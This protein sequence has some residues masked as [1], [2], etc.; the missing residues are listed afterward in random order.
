MSGRVGC[1]GRV[2]P[3]GDADPAFLSVPVLA[4]AFCAFLCMRHRSAQSV[5]ARKN[6]ERLVSL[7][8]W[9]VA[10]IVILTILRRRRDDDELRWLWF[11]FLEGSGSFSL[12]GIDVSRQKT[13]VTPTRQSVNK[14]EA[15]P[16]GHDAV[17]LHDR[18]GAGTRPGKNLKRPWRHSGPRRCVMQRGCPVDGPASH[19]SHCSPQ[20]GLT[21][22][23]LPLLSL[24]T[25]L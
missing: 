6:E 23:K 11:L 21:Y 3:R 24:F 1:V 25:P 22:R 13:D 5:E 20:R 17:Q 15:P 12:R 8:R 2:C 19:R 16:H 4:C 18:E 10:T 9:R 7:G 14:E